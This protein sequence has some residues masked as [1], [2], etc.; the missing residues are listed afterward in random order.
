MANTTPILSSS[1]SKAPLIARALCKDLPISVK[2]SIEVANALRY[3]TTSYAK[4]YLEQVIVLKQAVPFHRFHRDM[5]HKA[6][7]YSGRFPVN[8]AKEFLKLVKCVEANAQFKGI[9]ASNLK[10]IK[11]VAN[12]AS[13]PMG[14]GRQRHATRRSHLE[15]EVKQVAVKPVKK[16]Q[17]TKE[18]KN[19]KSLSKDK[20]TNANTSKS[21]VREA[22]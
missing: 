19:T 12:K 3:K 22:A 9:D 6:G 7:M 2:Q 18:P 10:I 14:G 4:N 1:S 13:I 21:K 8:T 15:I 16:A 17:H 5:G 20:D 11:L